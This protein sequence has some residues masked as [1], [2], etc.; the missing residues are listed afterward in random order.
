MRFTTYT[1]YTGGWIDALNLENLMELLSDFLM[2][3]GFAGGPNYHPYWGWSGT[4]DTS[5]VDALKHALLEA[6]LKSGP[7]T[8]EMLAEL[9]CEGA[10]LSLIHFSEPTRLQ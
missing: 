7:L 6:L 5:S 4:E 9:R 1:K 2:D 8:P 10:G 3:G